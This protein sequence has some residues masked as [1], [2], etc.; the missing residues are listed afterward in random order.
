MIL[1]ISNSGECLPI[2]WRL[3][4][5]GAE[6]GVYVHNPKHRPN[7]AGI[8]ER[9]TIGGLKKALKLAD[10]VIFDITH[11][12]QKKPEDIALLKM[13]GLKTGSPSVFGPV[14]DKLKKDQLVI[15]ASAW[16]EEIEMDRKL[17]SDIAEKLGLAI[18]ETHDFKALKQG[19]KFLKGRKDR[20]VLKPHH[21]ADL[22]L[23]YVERYPGELLRKF[24]GE[25]PRRVGEKFEFMLQ[26]V[27]EGV[28]ISTEGWFDGEKWHH[29][30]HT[31][32]DKRLMQGGLGPAIGSQGN[33]CWIKG[34]QAG[35]PAPLLVAELTKLTPWLKTAGYVGPV[36]INAIVSEEDH[37][38]YF[39]EFT[40][41]CG[42]DALYC[43]L[44]LLK[45]SLTE[46]WTK[47]FKG[48]FQYPGFASSQRLSIPPYPYA[49]RELL[50]SF[51]KEVP[52]EGSLEK[53]AW[54]W[55]EDIRMA[56][57]TPALLCCAGSDGI[58]GVVTGRGATVGEAVSKVY[59]RLKSMRVG[60]YMQYRLDGAKRPLAAIETL[61]K[62]GINVF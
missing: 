33:T 8:M 7:Y 23:T 36:D 58:L 38:P 52:I 29:F 26:R 49:N 21:N 34:V 11:P 27:V 15:G 19:V 6:V 9:V 43:L 45:G 24:E 2:A 48:E 56:G 32:E 47:G 62:W 1:F 40:P 39:L 12:N 51:A 3:K 55:G 60:A 18:S 25:L 10:K 31:I 14:A 22:D 4:R 54:F 41:R 13:F 17:G 53:M 35:K 57:E 37:R 42:Y 59:R 5:E 16:S 28:E 46:F 61:Q 44:T 50:A 20:W 30:N